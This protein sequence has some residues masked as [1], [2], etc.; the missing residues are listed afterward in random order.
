MKGS[1]AY[2]ARVGVYFSYLGLFPSCFDVVPLCHRAIVD[3]DVLKK[4]KWSCS[5]GI[6]P[7]AMLCLTALHNTS[8]YTWDA[9]NITICMSSI[10][11][12]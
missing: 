11:S 6:R 3:G 4:A 5:A 10:W 8:H 1:E 7:I 2:Q 9:N 12:D